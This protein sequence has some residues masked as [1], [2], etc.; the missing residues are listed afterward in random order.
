[1]AA[2]DRIRRYRSTGGA[3]DLARVE[4]LVPASGRARI[5]AEAAALRAENRRRNRSLTAEIDR[6][7][8]LY[9][10]RATDN[11]DLSKHA[12]PA[13]RARAVA[14]CLM[15]RGDARAFA[16]ALRLQRM[17]GENVDHGAH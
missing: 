15:E 11:I 14:R 3:A 13:A 17:A 5:L 7:V 9:G 2:Q 16:L 12:D 10:P 4:V 1:M 6:I 8:A